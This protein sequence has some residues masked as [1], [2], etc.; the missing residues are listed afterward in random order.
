MARAAHDLGRPHAAHGNDPIGRTVKVED[1]NVV[2]RG[3]PREYGLASSLQKPR[4]D[5]RGHLP[6]E[7]ALSWTEMAE[8][9]QHDRRCP[10]AGPE[11]AVRQARAQASHRAEC[12]CDSLG[13][14]ATAEKDQG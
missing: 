11:P 5:D 10:A 1:R 14:G 9:R 7:A 2:G 3:T 12:W 6:E 13:A 8:L 4:S